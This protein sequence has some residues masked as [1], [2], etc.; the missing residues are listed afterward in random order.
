MD[1][2]ILRVCRGFM[3]RWNA[4]LCRRFGVVHWFGP[5]YLIGSYRVSGLRCG[6]E[7]SREMLLCNVACW[8][9]DLR[10]GQL[11]FVVA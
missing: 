10:Y 11:D 6:S 4:E 3:V 1:W 2:W 5:N 8:Y 9:Y 7:D